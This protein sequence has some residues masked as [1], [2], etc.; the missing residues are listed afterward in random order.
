[1][2]VIIGRVLDLEYNFHIWEE[3]SVGSAQFM[4][5][6]ACQKLDLVNTRFKVLPFGLVDAEFC[7]LVGIQ[8]RIDYP[9]LDSS[10]VVCLTH[11]E[12]LFWRSEVIGTL[13]TL[14]CDEWANLENQACDALCRLAQASIQD[15]TSN[16]INRHGKV[17]YLVKWS[18]PKYI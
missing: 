9:I 4:E 5:I 15:M 18:R 7:G 16:W 17:S 10:I 11:G 3:C 8:L 1:M 6:L 14:V 13:R 2:V 12:G